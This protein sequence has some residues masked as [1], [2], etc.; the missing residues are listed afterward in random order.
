MPEIGPHLSRLAVR[1]DPTLSRPFV[2]DGRSIRIRPD[3]A[4]T[5]TG[6]ALI[7]REAIELDTVGFSQVTWADRILAHATAVVF[8]AT[9][10]MSRGEKAARETFSPLMDRTPDILALHNGADAA[11]TALAI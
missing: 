6:S 11:D 7:L 4:A 5:V 8:G 9:T 10:L 2:L 3:R 1:I